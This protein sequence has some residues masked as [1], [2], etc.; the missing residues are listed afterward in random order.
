MAQLAIVIVNHDRERALSKKLVEQKFVFTRLGS[1]GGFLRKR[2]ATLLIGLQDPARLTLL[3]NL[4]KG[5][6]E[7]REALVSAD[8][9]TLG[10]ETGSLE[11]P[12]GAA[13]VITGGATL[14]VVNL[15]E[16]TRY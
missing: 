6:S 7:Q 3:K 5:S 16:L 8:D 1:T 9:A 14:F 10:S 4:I 12:L 2:S 11:V 13:Q 15:E